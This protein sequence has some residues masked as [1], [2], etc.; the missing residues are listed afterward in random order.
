MLIDIVVTLVISAHLFVNVS[1]FF[2]PAN[3]ICYDD[4]TS[5][6]TTAS[7][8][9]PLPAPNFPY[10]WLIAIP[11]FS[12]S[13]APVH[14]TSNR[15]LGWKM[16]LDSRSRLERAIRDDKLYLCPCQSINNGGG[17]AAQSD[18]KHDRED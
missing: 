17:K 3:N 7:I 4:I 16:E 1:F 18:D 2:V 11:Q 10:L 5:S 14:P 15:R 12:T 13:S 8:P 9:P 6:L